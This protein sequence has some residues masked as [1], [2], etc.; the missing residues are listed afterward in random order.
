MS[1]DCNDP[2]VINDLEVLGYTRINVALVALNRNGEVLLCMRSLKKRL[3][4]GVWHFPGGKVEANETLGQALKREVSEELGVELNTSLLVD[5]S[6]S[7]EYEV[8][9]QK[10][11]TLFL[12]GSVSGQVRLNQEN[13]N[14]SWVGSNNLAEFRNDELLEK[15]QQIILKAK[16]QKIYSQDII[17]A[18]QN[19]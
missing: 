18:E 12:L 6:I 7:H 5:T 13:E 3:M 1:Y 4:P 19:L 9:G 16:S 11:I 14:A 15:Y 8:N 10:H 2:E 17:L